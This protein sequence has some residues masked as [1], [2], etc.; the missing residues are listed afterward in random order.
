M[1]NNE[2]RIESLAETLDGADLVTVLGCIANEEDI[3]CIQ[4]MTESRLFH[5]IVE[6]TQ[7]DFDAAWAALAEIALL[8]DE[9]EDEDAM[10]Q[11][12]EEHPDGD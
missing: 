9:D 8:L 2:A 12:R 7:S 6:A 3:T 1:T 11:Y 4:V 10:A 5:N